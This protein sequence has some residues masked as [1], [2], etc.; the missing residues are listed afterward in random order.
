MHG[1]YIESGLHIV[2]YAFYQNR[3]PYTILRKIH[4]YLFTAQGMVIGQGDS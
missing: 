2:I 3:V 1:N 4:T